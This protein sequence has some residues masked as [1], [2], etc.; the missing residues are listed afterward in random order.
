MKLNLAKLAS[1]QSIGYL[2]SGLKGNTCVYDLNLQECQLDDEDLEKIAYR[3]VDDNG[4]KNLKLGQNQ[5][6]NIESLI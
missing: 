4:I 3:L 2:M 6:T 1:K 5:F